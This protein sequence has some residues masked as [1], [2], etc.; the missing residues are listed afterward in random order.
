[1]PWPPSLRACLTDVSSR[2]RRDCAPNPMKALRGD[3]WEPHSAVFLSPRLGAL[4]LLR[5][6]GDLVG[7][8]EDAFRVLSR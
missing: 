1:M 3:P 5:T 4:G 8:N 6:L 2:F 7:N